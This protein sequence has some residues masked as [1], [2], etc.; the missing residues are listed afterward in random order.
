ML[1]QY[2]IVLN[3]KNVHSEE[4]FLCITYHASQRDHCY[5]SNVNKVPETLKGK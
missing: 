2:K 4:S 3:L 1:L 5:L